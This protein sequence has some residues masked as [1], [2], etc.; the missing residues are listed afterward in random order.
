MPQLRALAAVCRLAA[1]C[2]R[3]SDERQ[4]GP[5]LRPFVMRVPSAVSNRL[6]V[7]ARV[8]YGV[9]LVQD[10]TFPDLWSAFA[11]AF[12]H[13]ARQ[14]AEWGFGLAVREGEQAA[15]RGAISVGRIRWL[16]P[17]TAETLPYAPSDG[18]PLVATFGEE[19]AEIEDSLSL[20]FLTPTRLVA[21]GETLVTPDPAILVRRIAERLDAVAEGVGATKLELLSDPALSRALDGLR[22][23][24]SAISWIGD[25]TKGGFVGSA[26]LTGSQEDLAIVAPLLRWGAALGVGKGTLHG[27][28]RFVVGAVPSTAVVELPSRQ[29]DQIRVSHPRSTRRS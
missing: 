4:R 2:A 17:I 15:R 20:T 10:A 24:T 1:R 3:R 26:T 14:I 12:V 25:P 6:P 13:A 5:F 7:G 29:N 28:G 19:Q 18:P 11:D 22:I 9:T 27:A 16:N 23:G 8:T 21:A